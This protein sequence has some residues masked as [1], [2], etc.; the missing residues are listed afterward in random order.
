MINPGQHIK[1]ITTYLQSLFSQY[2]GANVIA[3]IKNISASR[4]PDRPD[5]IKIFYAYEAIYTHKYTEGEYY[6]SIPTA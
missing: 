1:N 6:L 5:T 4:S 3:E 2:R